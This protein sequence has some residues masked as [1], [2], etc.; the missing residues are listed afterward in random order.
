MI[1]FSSESKDI[2]RG[3]L[4]G[5]QQTT[6]IRCRN[7]WFENIEKEYYST[8]TIIEINLYKRRYH[9]ALSWS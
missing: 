7:I 9:R 1:I 5:T 2:T 8:G 3:K 6:M 4:P